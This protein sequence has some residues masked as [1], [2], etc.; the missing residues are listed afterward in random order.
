MVARSHAP[1]QGG[2]MRYDDVLEGIIPKRT[3]KMVRVVDKQ[4]YHL[5]WIEV[6]LDEPEQ[7]GSNDQHPQ[8]QTD[9]C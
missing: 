6:S 7:H 1:D 2:V 8:Q 9:D 3:T 4:G 5:R